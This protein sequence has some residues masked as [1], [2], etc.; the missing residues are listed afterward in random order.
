MNIPK[1]RKVLIWSL[2]V[3]G[4]PLTVFGFVH[5]ERPG[6]GAPASPD[7]LAGPKPGPVVM[8]MAIS[9][10]FRKTATEPNSLEDLVVHSPIVENLGDLTCWRFPFSYR[11]SSHFGGP[12]F[13]HGSFWV[14]DGHVV[15]EQWD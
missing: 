7:Q 10:A 15:K 4:L 9:E 12:T 3:L 8:S 14:K 1:D 6:Q 11:A 13:H 2:L 5:H